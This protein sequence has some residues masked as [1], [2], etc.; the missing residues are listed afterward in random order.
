MPTTQVKP[1]RSTERERLT[2]YHEAGHALMA[3][4]CGQHVTRVEIE[5]DDEHAGT[6]SALRFPPEI[7][8]PGATGTPTAALEARLLCLL[9]GMAAEAAAGGRQEWDER[10]AELDRAVRLAIQ[11]VGD[12][13]RVIP[14]L[15]EAREHATELLRSRWPAVEALAAELLGRRA[16]A[17]DEVRAVLAPLLGE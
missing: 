17:G 9:A 15:H 8:E 16:M 6:C 4:L 11:V 1:E 3:H 14:Y 13:E 12:C 7:D 10:S 2:A 5:G